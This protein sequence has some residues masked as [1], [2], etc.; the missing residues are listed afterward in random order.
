MMMI[1]MINDNNVVE[2]SGICTQIRKYKV[3]EV[4]TVTDL[5]GTDI[6]I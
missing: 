4:L 6:K 1:M 2:P 5:G 3:D